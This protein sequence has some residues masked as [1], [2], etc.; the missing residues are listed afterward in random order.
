MCCASRPAP[1]SP[2][3]KPF[4][5]RFRKRLSQDTAAQIVEVIWPLSVIACTRSATLGNK[6]IL[7][8]RTFIQ[9]TLR[10]SRTSYSTLQVALYYLIVVQSHIPKHDF[11]ME[12]PEDGPSLRA[13]QCGRRM[14][15]SAL[16]LAS[17]YL[18]DR[19]F[20]ARAWSK[21]SGLNTQEINMN[22]MTFLTAV[23]WRLHISES[24]FSRWTDIVI[25]YTTSSHQPPSPTG[26][27]QPTWRDIIP[28][29]TPELDHAALGPAVCVSSGPNKHPSTNLPS[30]HRASGA[31]RIVGDASNQSVPTPMYSIPRVLEPPA[32]PAFSLLPRSG[33]CSLRSSAQP[34]GFNTPAASAGSLSSRPSICSAM[35]QAQNACTVDRWIIPQPSSVAS[36]PSWSAVP[37]SYNNFRRSS[38]ARSCSSTSSPESMISDVSTPPSSRSSRSSSI[39]SVS[40]TICAPSNQANLAIQATCR[41]AKLSQLIKDNM[42]S[43]VWESNEECLYA[44]GMELLS[45]PETYVS[46]AGPVPDFTNFSL[47]TPTTT[48]R[49]SV[50]D[51]RSRKEFIA[52]R[53]C[54]SQPTPATVKC[55][56]RGRTSEDLNL[57]ENVRSLLSSTSSE[58]GSGQGPLK[59]E[60]STITTSLP[61]NPSIT[62]DEKTMQPPF[63]H[64]PSR[65]ALLKNMGRKRAC[66]SEEAGVAM[67]QGRMSGP[68]VAALELKDDTDSGGS[69]T[70]LTISCPEAILEDAHLGDSISINGTCLTITQ[71][72]PSTFKLG[73][74]PETLRRTNLGSLRKDSTVN[75]ERAVQANTRMG[76]HFVQGHVDTVATILAVTPDG[77]ALTF[78]LK[79]RDERVLQF[80]VEKGYITLDGAS[81]TITRVEDGEGWFE[82]MLIAYTQ[83]RVVMGQ[84]REDAE[85]NVEVDMVGKYVAKSVS[86]YMAGQGGEVGTAGLKL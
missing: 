33:T 1:E 49:E 6:G 84:K 30:L 3:N 86:A 10:R 42:K 13:L 43:T 55:K 58:I 54:R 7:P 44:S 9:E 80:V 63:R 60:F 77:N 68:A 25:K 17:K 61:P 50:T 74:S 53:N 23:N 8:L 24:V 62:F 67:S 79:P 47:S 73:V 82:V 71:L 46:P 72:S 35:A 83:E 36:T 52:S 19:N 57:Q 22:E 64:S 81:L 5:A 4:I 15:L 26:S 18:Q 29:L 85:V 70:S 32:L 65:V 21:I 75:V 28:M 20:S 39:S 27:P 37:H 66:C 40:S 78:R 45:S 34:V 48:L 14:F 76:G 11:T 16:I 12:Q 59:Q 31:G 69:G 41:N 56:K 38:L 2:T 51:P